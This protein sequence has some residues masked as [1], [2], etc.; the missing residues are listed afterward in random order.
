MHM[1]T[2]VLDVGSG[3]EGVDEGNEEALQT[4]LTG[5]LVLKVGGCGESG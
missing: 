2:E 4:Y 1:C 3:M 5:A